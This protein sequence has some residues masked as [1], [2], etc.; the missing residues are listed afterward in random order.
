MSAKTDQTGRMRRLIWVFAG[1]LYLIVGFVM[2]LLIH[3]IE[4]TQEMPQSWST[5]FPNTKRKDKTNVTVEITD[6]QTKKNYNKGTVLERSTEKK[7]YWET[8]AVYSHG[9]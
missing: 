5:A 8:K 6:V 7:K 9:T 1:R 4:N 3:R 2:L